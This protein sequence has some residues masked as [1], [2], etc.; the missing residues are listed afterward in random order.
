MQKSEK[1]WQDDLIKFTSITLP[2][3]EH[4]LS[5][6]IFIQVCYCVVHFGLWKFGIRRRRKKRRVYWNGLVSI[7]ALPSHF[8]KDLIRKK[9]IIEEKYQ[10][11]VRTGYNMVRT[12]SNRVQTSF[13]GVRI[14]YSGVQTGYIGLGWSPLSWSLYFYH[15]PVPMINTL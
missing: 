3:Y 13:I 1:V 8:I 6:R 2:N 11:C 5:P 4:I 14:G 15:K 7:W 12:G 10:D 9:K